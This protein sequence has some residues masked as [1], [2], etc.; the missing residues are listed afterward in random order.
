MLTRRNPQAGF[1]LIEIILATG[2]LATICGFTITMIA[3]QITNRN[4]LQ[5]QDSTY[6][7]MHVAMSHLYDD[8]RH[9][10]IKKEPAAYGTQQTSTVK[11]D[12]VWHGST[13]IG[14]TYFITQ[15][16]RSYTSNSPQSNIAQIRYERRKDSTTNKD[17]LWRIVDTDLAESISLNE[18][19][20]PEL[21]VDDLA[22]FKV[23]FW[24]GTDF[25][26]SG[27]WDS[28]QADYKDK[29]PKMVK[30]HLECF[31]P[32]TEGEKQRQELDASLA[33]E[34]RKVVLET[35]VYVLQSAG[36]EQVKSPA[37][38]YKWQ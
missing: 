23:S 9:I 24:D 17:Q 11:Y 37:L 2:I 5:A 26:S 16:Y 29:L 30:I 18:V 12:L 14:Q 19:G 3:T 33:Q 22:D 31:Q 8:F 20:V 32:T 21:L 15:N 7:M 13:S 1:T 25:N 27:E 28:S 36:Q 10:L 4:K 35:I 38:E 6:H 34:P